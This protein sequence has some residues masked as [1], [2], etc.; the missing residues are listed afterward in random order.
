M[1][2]QR[3]KMNLISQ[4]SAGKVITHTRLHFVLQSSG[5]HA[6]V[7]NQNMQKMDIHWYILITIITIINCICVYYNINQLFLLSNFMIQ[8]HV[9]DC[10]PLTVIHCFQHTWL[11][12]YTI[13]FPTVIPIAWWVLFH[14]WYSGTSCKWPPLMPGLGGRLWE[15]VA[16]RKFH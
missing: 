11:S 9:I 13:S 6:C 16:Y 1:D 7:A 14:W 5:Y 12:F 15:V 8:N 2:R 3:Q 10:D 4:N